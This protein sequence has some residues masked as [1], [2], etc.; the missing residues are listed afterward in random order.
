MFDGRSNSRHTLR[1]CVNRSMCLK[2]LK[3]LNEI[4]PVSNFA[5]KA[6][7]HILMETMNSLYVFF[8]YWYDYLSFKDFCFDSQVVSLKDFSFDSRVMSLLHMIRNKTKR[9]KQGFYT[10]CIFRSYM[11][12]LVSKFD[13]A[14]RKADISYELLQNVI[15]FICS[16]LEIS[17]N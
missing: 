5:I 7:T 2:H 9:Y 12:C 10:R 14:C 16:S 11:L 17:T 4:W 15:N 3:E 13:P 8:I 1:W 6:E